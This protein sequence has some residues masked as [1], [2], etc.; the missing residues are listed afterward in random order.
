MPTRQEDAAHNRGQ[1][2]VDENAEGMQQAGRKEKGLRHEM[3]SRVDASKNMLSRE[4][5]FENVSTGADRKASTRELVRARGGL[6]ERLQRRVI[7][8]ALRKS[9]SPF[10]TEVV[11][12]QAASTKGEAGVKG[13]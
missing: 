4:E 11:E 10:R 6:L 1:H 9:G 5:V 7:L 12:S 2:R 8:E 13:H 3:R